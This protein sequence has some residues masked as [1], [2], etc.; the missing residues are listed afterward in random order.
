MW[1]PGRSPRQLRLWRRG[2]RGAA[3]RTS[4]ANRHQSIPSRVPRHLARRSDLPAR[5][6]L[7]PRRHPGVEP[8][9][10]HVPRTRA[11]SNA[12]GRA[13]R[14]AILRILRIFCRT[15]TLSRKW[16]ARSEF[17][18]VQLRST[19][20]R[21][22]GPLRPR[23]MWIPRCCSV[24]PGGFLGE[25]VRVARS[26]RDTS[27]LGEP[28]HVRLVV[29]QVKARCCCPVRHLCGLQPIRS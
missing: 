18:W 23:V 21:H 10:L 14:A 28:L 26:R 3:G 13:D 27:R 11:R 6:A 25:A 17:G 9:G 5:S 12:G 8:I 24:R 20:L 4:P 1:A 19:W 15:L 16:C 22:L 29:F 2:C 7:L